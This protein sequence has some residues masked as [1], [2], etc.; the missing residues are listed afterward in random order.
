MRLRSTLILGA[1]A[2]LTACSDGGPTYYRDVRPIVEGRCVRCHADGAI[3][4]FALDDYER[5]RAF[6]PAVAQAVTTREMPPWSAGPAEVEYA[7]D[8][9]LS[10]AQIATIVDWVE[11]GME[12]GDASSPGDPIEEVEPAFPGADIELELPEPY[13]PSQPDDYRCFPV[14]WTPTEEKFVTAMNVL[15]GNLEIVHHVGVFL[16]PPGN[17]DKPFEWNAEDETPG[18]ECFGGPSGGRAAIPIAQLGAWLPGQTGNVYPNGV[19]IR[20]KPGSTLVIQMHYN[21]AGGEPAPDKSRI[22]FSVADSVD[23]EGWYAPFL[24]VSWVIGEMSIPAGEAEV[25][26]T[27][28]ADPRDFFELVA[29]QSLPF[30]DGFEIHAVMFHM[31]QL[32]ERGSVARVHRGRETPFLNIER[33]DFNWQRQYVLS[34]PLTVEDGDELSLRCVFD[35][36]AANQDGGGVP[37]DVNWGEGTDDEMCV[38]NLL[39]T[40]R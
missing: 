8:V 35:N 24:D 12:E 10:D 14:R 13:V 38:A 5:V 22:Q 37:R 39:V 1:L 36:S 21:V 16:I 31:H 9:S 30:E 7:G 6:G 15:P 34:E 33:W 18:Y 3:A 19:G 27:V 25:V 17:A 26:H 32:G 20:V 40:A 28:K 29:G 2:G 4:P 23:K 11:A